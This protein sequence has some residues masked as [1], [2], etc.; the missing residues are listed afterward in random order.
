MLCVLKLCCQNKQRQNTSF[1]IQRNTILLNCSCSIQKSFQFRKEQTQRIHMS[2]T[3]GIVEKS[4]ASIYQLST[5][6]SEWN[7]IEVTQRH[8]DIMTPRLK[9][10]PRR[11]IFLAKNLKR[12]FVYVEKSV[13]IVI[14]RF[15]LIN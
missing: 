11:L 6:T 1:G 15:F 7:H 3:S 2:P 9:L 10:L 4:A 13:L 5:V 14:F 12:V 8:L